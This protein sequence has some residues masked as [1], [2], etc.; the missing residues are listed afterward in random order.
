MK[1]YCT[2]LLDN[3]KQ[4][5]HDF[6]IASDRVSAL[7]IANQWVSAGFPYRNCEKKCLR[8]KDRKWHF[9]AFVKFSENL[10]IQSSWYLVCK[11]LFFLTCEKWLRAVWEN[12]AR[13]C[14]GYARAGDEEGKEG[15]TNGPTQTKKYIKLLRI[16]LFWAYQ[17]NRREI[18]MS[19]E[20]SIASFR[21]VTNPLSRL[22]WSRCG[23]YGGA[24]K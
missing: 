2:E 6:D 20:L 13:A 22:P 5:G 7:Q 18:L 12:S 11:L 21:P 1:I 15:G 8:V 23:C 10:Q 3:C 4:A 16:W 19:G 9:Y 17:R 14:D 24:K